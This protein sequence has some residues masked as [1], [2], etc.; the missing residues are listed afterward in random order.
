[1]ARVGNP[2][3]AMQ[4]SA[5]ISLLGSVLFGA[6]GQVLLK[7][8]ATGK[9]RFVDFLNIQILGGLG[10]Y[11]LGAMLWI[12]A[13]SVAPLYLVYPFTMLTF[14][15]VALAS[16]LYLGEQPSG[17]S[18]SGWCVTLLGIALVSLGSMK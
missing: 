11:T 6:C 7:L 4:R 14:V 8:G 3:K 5:F 16:V 1:L 17:L 2:A 10:S 15:L 18:I 12:Y 13:L 9:M